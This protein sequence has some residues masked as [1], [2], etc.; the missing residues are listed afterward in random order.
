[1]QFTSMVNQTFTVMIVDTRIFNNFDEKYCF[2]STMGAFGWFLLIF[3][4]DTLEFVTL[5]SAPQPAVL[6]LMAEMFL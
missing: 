6:N 4:F 1:M 3:G 5:S 2:S